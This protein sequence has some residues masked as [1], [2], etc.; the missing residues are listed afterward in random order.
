MTSINIHLE[1]I[2]TKAEDA[3]Q[4]EGVIN[5]NI[6]KALEEQGMSSIDELES[7]LE[8]EWNDKLQ[9]E[10]E[11]MLGRIGQETADVA[12]CISIVNYVGVIAAGIGLTGR[13]CHLT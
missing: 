4:Y 9:R 11:A 1:A 3:K 5:D 6:E 12:R 13:L 7:S 10:N 8:G 2:E